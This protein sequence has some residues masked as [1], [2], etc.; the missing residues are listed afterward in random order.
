MVIS[1]FSR[2]KRRGFE[3]C[4]DNTINRFH[5]IGLNLFF[6]SR[7]CQLVSAFLVLFRSDTI[8]KY[9]S[10]K[11][12]L[13][14]KNKVTNY[15]VNLNV[16][17]LHFKILNIVCNKSHIKWL[18]TQKENKICLKPSLR[19]QL[20]NYENFFPSFA[21][22]ANLTL[23]EDEKYIRQI[24]LTNYFQLNNKASPN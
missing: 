13:I 20:V 5:S 12:N 6:N 15:F 9:T 23:K 16:C 24:N 18:E 4:T 21:F 10:P 3:S 19:L 1:F 22:P 7:K 2:L 8:I 17:F 14:Y 11:K